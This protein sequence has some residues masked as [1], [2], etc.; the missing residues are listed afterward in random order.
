MPTSPHARTIAYGGASQRISIG[1][2]CVAMLPPL[3]TARTPADSKAVMTYL[4][5]DQQLQA[6][7]VGNLLPLQVPPHLLQRTL[8]LGVGDVLVIAPQRVKPFAQV[9][10]QIVVVIGTAK[11][12]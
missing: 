1:P 4:I 2:S 8:P 9:V 3:R 10:N 6:L 7:D 5:G 11:R 12:F